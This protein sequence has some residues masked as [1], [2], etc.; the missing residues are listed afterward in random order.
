MQQPLMQSPSG[1]ST[2]HPSQCRNLDLEFLDMG[3]QHWSS[4]SI[5]PSQT[6]NTHFHVPFLPALAPNSVSQQRLPPAPAPLVVS[7]QKLPPAPAH[8][9]VSQ[10][11]LPPPASAPLLVSQQQLPP[12]PVPLAVA[13]HQLPQTTIHHSDGY[14]LSGQT[15]LALPS[16]NQLSQEAESAI[17]KAREELLG[18]QGRKKAPGQSQPK[19]KRASR[20]KSAPRKQSAPTTTAEAK[21]NLDTGTAGE[22]QGD[23]LPPPLSFDLQPPAASLPLPPPTASLP[24][25]LKPTPASRVRLEDDI[26]AQYRSLPLD[27]LHR[28]ALE[29]AKNARLCAE[30]R[31]ELDGLYKN[32]QRKIYITAIKNK[33]C[34]EP[35]LDHLG[36]GTCIK[37]S[38]CYNN[39]CQYDP[40]ASK[41]HTDKSKSSQQ[42]AHEMGLLWQNETDPQKWYDTEFLDSLPNPYEADANQAKAK[43]LNE[44]KK[45]KS[46]VDMK[47]DQWAGKLKKLSAAYGIEGFL[48]LASRHKKRTVMTSG[49]SILGVSFL[50]M[51]PDDMDVRTNFLNYVKGQ[52]AIVKVT[53][54]LPPPPKKPRKQC[55]GKSDLAKEK[56]SH[57][58][59]AKKPKNLNALRKLLVGELHKAPNARWKV[60]NGWP[61]TH[62]VE[63]LKRVGVKMQVK[64]D[65]ELMISPKDFCHRLDQLHNSELHRLLVVVGE[66]WFELHPINTES[67]DVEDEHNIKAEPGDDTGGETQTAHHSSKDNRTDKCTKGKSKSAKT[68]PNDPNPKPTKS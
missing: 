40:E 50:D 63:S 52:N 66:G 37:G 48:V 57:Y 12:A 7:Q 64:K 39:F 30:D 56:Y 55:T 26:V 31:F 68:R 60:T 44:D 19:R 24:R 21:L 25:G 61:G 59:R 22:S 45:R 14:Q 11:Q 34:I 62:T 49:G 4:N 29:H 41:I 65:N 20:K 17:N 28:L 1:S 36:L 54:S 13:Q 5:Q 18:K 6:S 47:P 51:F 16:F 53:G 15:T 46:Y 58:N 35:V 33:L 43:A 23:T 27:E 38:T 32:Y 42:R 8:I 2:S 9:P 67:V 10:Q 3:N